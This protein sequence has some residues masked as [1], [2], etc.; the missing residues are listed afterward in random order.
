[1]AMLVYLIG[2]FTGF[3]GPL[4]MYFI[5]RDSKFVSFHAL[6]SLFWHLLYMATMIALAMLFFVLMFASIA[7][8][9]VL[10]HGPGAPAPVGAF[11]VFPLFWIVITV[12]WMTNLV[13][14]VVFAI[15]ANSGEW[16]S[17]P[18]VGRW[19]RRA[20]GI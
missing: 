10:H 20:A 12:F 16:A 9:V 15:K 13:L 7:F 5:K 11:L 4:I 17:Y 19:A 3:V 14:A 8:E 1:M 6:Q 18:I 2:I